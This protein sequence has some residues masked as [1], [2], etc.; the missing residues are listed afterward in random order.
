MTELVSLRT[1]SQKLLDMAPEHMQSCLVASQKAASQLLTR[2]RKAPGATTNKASQCDSRLRVL[3]RGD[4]VC[5]FMLAGFFASNMNK[6]KSPTAEASAL[7]LIVLAD[8]YDHY[9][10]KPFEAAAADLAGLGELIAHHPGLR[11]EAN[12]LRQIAE[13]QCSLSRLRARTANL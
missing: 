4:K 12:A 7:S 3:P 6:P 11:T 13:G 5:A 9:S 10:E 8:I 2:L 1:P